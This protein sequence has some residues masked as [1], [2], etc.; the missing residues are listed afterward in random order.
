MLPDAAK[1]VHPERRILAIC[2]DAG[3]LMNVHEMETAR[4]LDANIAVMAWEDG[5]TA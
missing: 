1:R 2:D 3:F 5:R 4:R